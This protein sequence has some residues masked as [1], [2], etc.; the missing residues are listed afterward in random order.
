MLVTSDSL[1]WF[2]ELQEKALSSRLTVSS[3]TSSQYLW[4]PGSERHIIKGDSWCRCQTTLKKKYL[5]AIDLKWS[6]NVFTVDYRAWMASLALSEHW[7]VLLK[8]KVSQPTPSFSLPHWD[9][10]KPKWSCTGQALTLRVGGNWINW[11]CFSAALPAK[12]FFLCLSA[13]DHWKAVFQLCLL[14]QKTSKQL[15]TLCMQSQKCLFCLLTLSRL[16]LPL[17]FYH[18]EAL[19]LKWKEEHHRGRRQNLQ[20]LM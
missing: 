1:T 15:A 9:H 13:Q 18:C 12:C 11:G 3:S 4:K 2:A 17:V 19:V 10:R 14:I 20:L 5:H 7:F 8:T 6:K 16:N